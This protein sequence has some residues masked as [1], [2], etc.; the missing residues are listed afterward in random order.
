MADKTNLKKALFRILLVT[1]SFA[2]SLQAFACVNV[3]SKHVITP[4]TVSPTLRKSRVVIIAGTNV[5]LWTASFVVLNNTWYRNYPRTSFHLFNDLPEWNQMDK[6]GHVWT[7]YHISRLS[8]EMWNWTGLDKKKSAVLGGISG[9]AYEG[10]IELQDGYSAQ[11][12]FS[13]SDIAANIAGAAFFV[14]QELVWDEQRIQFKLGYSPYR[15]APDLVERR[16]QLFGTGTAERILKDYNSQTYWA[17]ANLKSFFPSSNLPK[18]LN[19]SAGYGSDGMFGGR[20]NVWTDKLGNTINKTSVQRI[21][22]FYLAPDV[23]LTKIKTKSR[24]LST[25]F[26]LVNMVKFPAP[27]VEINSNGKVEFHGIKF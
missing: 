5:A 13:L 9:L 7:T 2:G 20:Q 14:S 27:A 10:I 21:R 16:N 1:G 18:W 24:L 22:R 17:S 15:Y 19:I 25:V 3:V 4:D 8:S 23:D 12:G 26:Y 6:A 11:W